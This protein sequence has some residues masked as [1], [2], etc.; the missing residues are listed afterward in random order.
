MF[1]LLTSCLSHTEKRGYIFDFSDH[2]FVQEGITSKERLLRMMGSPT[3]ISDFD[4][5]EAWIYF[6]EDLNKVLFF[7]PDIVS[8]TILVIRFNQFDTVKKLEKIDLSAEEKTSEFYSGFTE[9]KS[10]KEGFFK[11]IFGNIGKISAQQ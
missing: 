2:E 4:Q 3:I 8:R 7:K 1:L 9:V 10:Q 5:D 6:S 11:S